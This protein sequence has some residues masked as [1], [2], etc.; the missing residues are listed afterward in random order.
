MPFMV[1]AHNFVR[2][3][4]CPFAR[5]ERLVPAAGTIHD[6]GCGHG[7][8][9]LYLALSSSRRQVIGYDLSEEKIA[10]A[11]KAAAS[12]RNVAFHSADILRASPGRCD[13]VVLLDVLY[14]IDYPRQEQ[15]IE[16]SLN[17]LSPGGT[18]VIKTTDTS[19]R[20]KY[21]ISY[22]QEFLA[23][24]M[25][26]ITLGKGLYFRSRDEYAAILARYGSESS[27]HRI[28]KGY[29]HSHT[30]LIGRKKAD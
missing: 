1:R 13:T 6:L 24:R 5:I 11:R 30:I 12:V 21:L 25:L 19:P 17:A 18:M 26:G 14:L 8:F 29:L 2:Q 22:A 4:T 27:T 23:V 20:W 16:R 28:D 10:I 9:S 7:L 3:A 15:I